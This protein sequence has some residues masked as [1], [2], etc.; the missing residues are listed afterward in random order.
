MIV[1]SVEVERADPSA[2][3]D[4]FEPTHWVNTFHLKAGWETKKSTE[5]GPALS[6]ADQVHRGMNADLTKIVAMSEQLIR[7]PA[8]EVFAAFVEPQAL[9]RY[10]L[11]SASGPLG[12][13]RKVRWEFMVKGAASDVEVL[14]FEPDRRIRLGWDDGSVTEWIF[15][16]TGE[17][18]TIVRVEQSGFSGSADEI[19]SAVI[20]ATQGYTIVLCGLKVLLEGG[21]TRLVGDK[22]ELIERTRKVQQGIDEKL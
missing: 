19:I 18:G 17:A 20:N 22:A 21:G 13:G 6:F 12:S 7:K 15:T 1:R 2:F 8:R 4:E 9:T 10:W 16:P 14:A 3:S 11:A 5:E